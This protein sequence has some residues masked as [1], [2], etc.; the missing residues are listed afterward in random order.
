MRFACRGYPGTEGR[1]R[2]E[3]LRGEHVHRPNRHPDEVPQIPPLTV[4]ATDMRFEQADYAGRGCFCSRCGQTI[5]EGVVALRAWPEGGLDEYRYHPVCFGAEPQ[6]E[7]PYAEEG[8]A[9]EPD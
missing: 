1:I 8:L 6:S 9:Y 4:A 5:F 7:D 3:D 2:F